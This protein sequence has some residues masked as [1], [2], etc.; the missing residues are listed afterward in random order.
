[1]SKS[2]EPK[3]PIRDGIAPLVDFIEVGCLIVFAAGFV[4]PAILQ[5]LIKW[6]FK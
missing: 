4:I 1:M 2:D 5:Y 6:L 3:E